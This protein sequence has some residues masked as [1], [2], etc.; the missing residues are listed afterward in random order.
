M[1]SVAKKKKRIIAFNFDPPPKVSFDKADLK[2]R[3][4]ATAVLWA[5]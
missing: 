2:R 5:Q 4:K 1:E 3:R